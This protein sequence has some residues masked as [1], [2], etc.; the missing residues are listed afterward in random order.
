[1]KDA[2]IYIPC[3]YYNILILLRKGFNGKVAEIFSLRIVTRLL[4]ISPC[5]W[6][7]RPQNAGWNQ[8][9]LPQNTR[10][11]LKFNL[12]YWK[13]HLRVYFQMLA[14]GD[15]FFPFF[16]EISIKS[17]EFQAIPTF[18]GVFD[19]FQFLNIKFQKVCFVCLL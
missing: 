9:K 5:A 12:F 1:M 17:I 11:S 19:W 16:F 18:W 4:C 14:D 3:V 2:K 7:L 8:S 6:V 15:N 13:R 10:I